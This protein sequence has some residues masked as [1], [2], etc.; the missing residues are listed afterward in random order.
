MPDPF[1]LSTD[2][3]PAAGPISAAPRTLPWLADLNPE[4]REAVETTDGPLLVLSGAGTGKTRV[5]TCRVAYILAKGL[6]KPWQILAVTFTNRAAKEMRER[7]ATLVGPVA[8]A[9]WLGTFHALCVRMLRRHGEL[10]G[11]RSSFTILDSDDQLRLLKQV[12]EADEID[13]KKWPA[14][15]LMGV[16]SS[17]SSSVSWSLQCSCSVTQTHVQVE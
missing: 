2:A 10:I 1:D 17:P 8:E 6:A 13:I 4:Q 15:A 16:S 9:V 12:M 5:L 14:Q 11:L 3:E 7:V